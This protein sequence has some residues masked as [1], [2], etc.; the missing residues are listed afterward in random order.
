MARGT[1][2]NVEEV[3]DIKKVTGSKPQP[4]WWGYREDLSELGDY[5]DAIEYDP[6]PHE[7]LRKIRVRITKAANSL[8]MTVMNRE[9][10]R[11]TLLVFRPPAEGSRR[12]GGRR[13]KQEQG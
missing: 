4:D 6:E 13:K 11:A 1:K 2:V 9:T 7:N 10:E 12:R 8:N 3:T 5:P